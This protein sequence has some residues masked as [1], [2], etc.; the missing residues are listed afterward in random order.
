MKKSDIIL[1][2]FL[3][4]LLVFLSRWK[5]FLTPGIIGH[6]W[7]W[8]IAFLKE[9]N[10]QALF[11]SLFVWKDSS[12]GYLASLNI[13]Q[14]PLLL[15]GSVFGGDTGSKLFFF[16]IPFL[17]FIN[18]SIFLKYIGEKILERID[19]YSVFLGAVIY[20]FFPIVF[21][22]LVG[23]Q[24]NALVCYAFFP[25]FFYYFFNFF[26]KDL[27]WKYLFGLGI[28]L[29]LFC[30]SQILYLTMGISIFFILALY[31]NKFKSLIIFLVLLFLVG[32][33]VFFYMFS[34][35]DKVNEILPNQ[36]KDNTLIR[37]SLINH[38]ETIDKVF[39]GEGYGDRNLFQN[40]LG[41]YRFVYFAIFYFILILVIYALFV[42]K[43]KF[44]DK[45]FILAFT[46]IYLLGLFL[47]TAG[48]SPFGEVFIY[49]MTHFTLM[50]IFRSF[51][52]F[53]VLVAFPFSVM[54]TVAFS[55]LREKF[56]KINIIVSILFLIA[57]LPV[58]IEGDN[59]IRVLKGLKKDSI[60]IYQINPNFLDILKKQFRDPLWYRVLY[61][62]N[63][64]SPSYKK[65][66]YQRSGQGG[67]PEFGSS[68]KPILDDFNLTP[69]KTKIFD[70][71]EENIINSKP[72]DQNFLGFLSFKKIVRRRDVSPSFSKLANRY[73]DE[74]ID[75]KLG[76]LENISRSEYIDY[77]QIN[78]KYYLPHFYVPE[79]IIYSDGDIESL[80]DIVGFEDYQ[81]RSAIY[82]R[83]INELTDFKMNELEELKK[84][85]DKVF[86]KGELENKIGEEELG[87]VLIG[88]NLPS[89]R[90]RP[91]Y[92]LYPL[93]LKKEE[94]EKWQIRN[95]PEDLFEK[96]LFYASKRIAEMEK[97][98]INKINKLTDYLL[99][100]YKKEMVDALGILEKFRQSKDKN[101][102][103]LLAKYKGTLWGHRSK[104]NELTNYSLTD[105]KVAFEELEGQAEELKIKRDFSTLVYRLDVPKE[106]EYEVYVK[107]TDIRNQ[108]LDI[109]ER[110][111]ETETDIR[112][113]KLDIGGQ[114]TGEDT[115]NKV[116]TNG[117]WVKL[118]ER[119]FS[120]GGQ[121]LV[122]PFSGI[123]ENL[124]DENL[125]IKDYQPD[126]IYRIIF[127]YKAPRGG[128]FF[129]AEGKEGEKT[130]T[131]LVSTDE[132]FKHFE[133]FFKSSSKV[134]D[135][136]VHLSISVAEEKNLKVERIYQPEILLR[137]KDTGN[138][139]LDIGKTIPKITFVKI[140]PTKYRVKVEGATQPYTL[141]FSESFH[142]GWKIYINELTDSK[143]NELN[144]Y[145]EILASYFDG[146]IKEGTHR[147]IFLDRNT[148]ETWGKKPLPEERHLLV[149]GYANSWYIKPEDAGGHENYEIIIEFAPQKIFYIGLG[150]SL[151]T[152]LGC[153]GYLGISFF[154][155]GVKLKIK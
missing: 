33:P 130:Q 12:F 65:T 89:V 55:S 135:A 74:T 72:I 139:I 125:R 63:T 155:K 7:D 34:N 14:F 46:I 67:D 98:K 86:V 73:S 69:E 1:L 124:V 80:A 138:Q 51:F 83:N 37:Q 112:N 66:S 105:W 116:E 94:Y 128:G 48:R 43:G 127:D 91:D 92:F 45:R 50:K 121:E 154:K 13:F 137:Q 78:S 111:T 77:Y 64:V 131:D 132:K 143:I 149:N 61:V 44:K 70:L 25:L 118:E 49:L 108:I 53:F 47:V 90:W 27:C 39:T 123:S 79:N 96:H 41:N 8:S 82:L 129:V 57:I 153:L 30:S 119:N 26:E 99:M 117:G 24:T 134:T 3:G 71:I 4:F 21:N 85:V 115:G 75:K 36:L 151:T 35:M 145:G 32:N 17:S 29:F 10:Y 68:P 28:L 11:N 52:I 152:L 6:N 107:D 133:M 142:E 95:K 97:F 22:N 104:I 62:P 59:G 101:F 81:I 110:G 113:L 5:L 102:S 42:R 54:V 40:F 19:I 88:V 31:R 15:L 136:S 120:E 18:S 9:Q 2:F 140:N 93:I 146:E 60:D 150:I 20:T 16:L 87:S 23:G 100:N 126:A 141:V 147:N 76:E 122:L 38:L 109:S 114:G 148:F 58:F 144:N 103:K 56:K 106:G 84:K